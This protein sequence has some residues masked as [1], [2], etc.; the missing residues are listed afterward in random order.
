MFMCHDPSDFN[1]DLNTLYR[2]LFADSGQKNSQCESRDILP[3]IL[4][5]CG[6]L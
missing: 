4:S 5:I 2:D 3:S 6:Q 1:I